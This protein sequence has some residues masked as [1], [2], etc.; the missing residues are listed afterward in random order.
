MHRIQN[1][2]ERF[3]M[4][5]DGKLLEYILAVAISHMNMG[6]SEGLTEST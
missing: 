6:F 4:G 5:I 1:Y 3:Y 2:A